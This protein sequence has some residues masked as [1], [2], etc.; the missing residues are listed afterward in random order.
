MKAWSWLLWVLV[1]L[2]GWSQET[3][4]INYPYGAD[5]GFG[6]FDVDGRSVQVY[7]IPFG[8]TLREAGDERTGLRLTLPLGFGVHDLSVGFQEGELVETIRTIS[9]VPGLEWTVPIG[10]WTLEPFV[11]AGAAIDL[12]EDR[13][14]RLYA[15]GARANRRFTVDALRWT[16]GAELGTDG[17]RL[18]DGATDGYT[19]ADAGLDMRFP[20]SLSLAAHQLDMSLYVIYRQYL[21]DLEFERAE[22]APIEL[23]HHLELGVT[24]GTVKPLIV[25]GQ[26]LPRVGLSYRGTGD[27]QAWR[28][29]FGFP[30]QN[31]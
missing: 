10:D 1:A 7:R 21:T 19:Y 18:G 27:L 25:F 6:E 29:N 9:L 17:S 15:A 3:P 2:A 11:E 30:L 20:L 13:T 5:I 4:R 26:K 31:H 28:L 8:W 22:T 14:A 12:D 23:D 24:F 16:L